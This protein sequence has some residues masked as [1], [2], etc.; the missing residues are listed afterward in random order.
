MKKILI[1][2]FAI[3]MIISTEAFAADVDLG[4]ES[5]ESATGYKLYMS[6]DSGATWSAPI[7]VGDVITFTYSG[8]PIDKLVLFRVSAYNDN[9]ETIRL[10][11]GAW[12]N[13]LWKPPQAAI[14][15]GIR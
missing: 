12:Y 13:E 7:D 4:W 6:E 9:G 8:V 1:L 15:L 2:L 3:C 5:V 10:W 11:S 14:G